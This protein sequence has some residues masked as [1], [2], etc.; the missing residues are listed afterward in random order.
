M[1]IKEQHLYQCVVAREQGY[2]YPRPMGLVA[3]A[4]TGLVWTIGKWF[5]ALLLFAALLGTVNRFLESHTP[6]GGNEPTPATT[7]ATVPAD[8]GPVSAPATLAFLGSTTDLLDGTLHVTL[9]NVAYAGS[10]I[11]EIGIT[12]GDG[13]S[14][15]LK[16]VTYNP[17]AQLDY[18][19]GDFT[20]VVMVQDRDSGAREFELAGARYPRRDDLAPCV[21]K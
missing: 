21:Q 18:S 12:D 8:A 15:R 2:E 20:Y 13:G 6:T 17:T 1:S 3:G 14:C 9:G 11:D 19:V 5:L 10:P 16:N 7:P 4:A